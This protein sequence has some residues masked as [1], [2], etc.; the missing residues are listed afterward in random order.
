MANPAY[1]VISID[2]HDAAAMAPYAAGATPLIEG[3]QWRVHDTSRPLPEVVAS[4]GSLG[5]V[6]PPADAL[7]LFDGFNLNHFSNKSLEIV[8]G[9]MVMGEGGQR[10]PQIGWE[11]LRRAVAV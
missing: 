10:L 9:A 7:V 2:I 8:N 6:K 5:L 4:G 11:I 3:Q 1:M